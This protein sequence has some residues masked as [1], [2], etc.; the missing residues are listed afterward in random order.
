MNKELSSFAQTTTGLTKAF[1]LSAFKKLPS[2][3]ALLNAVC[4]GF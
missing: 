2:L 3:T 1:A 4:R